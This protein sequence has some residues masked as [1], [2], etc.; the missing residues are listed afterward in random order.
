MIYMEINCE[1]SPKISHVRF[2]DLSYNTHVI[3]KTG[4]CLRNHTMVYDDGYTCLV[5]CGEAK[6]GRLHLSNRYK[7]ASMFGSIQFLISPQVQNPHVNIALC[8][9]YFLQRFF[10]CCG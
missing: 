2:S 5:Q 6:I 1:H 3:Y 8:K 9:V 10:S 4:Q 7:Q